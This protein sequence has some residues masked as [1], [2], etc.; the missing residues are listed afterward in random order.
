MQ[1]SGKGKE[2]GWK[3]TYA[4]IFEFFAQGAAAEA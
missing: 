3:L 2:K 4:V 1:T